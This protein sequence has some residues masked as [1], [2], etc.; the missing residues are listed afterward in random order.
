VSYARSAKAV[1]VCHNSVH[2]GYYVLTPNTPCLKKVPTF[3]LVV[4]LSNLNGFSKFL[5]CGKEYRNLLQNPYDITHFTLGMLLHWLGKLKTQIFCRYSADIEED[6]NKL[7]F[8]KLSTFELRDLGW[9]TCYIMSEFKSFNLYHRCLNMTTTHTHGHSSI[10]CR[11]TIFHNIWRTLKSRRVATGQH[12][13]QN[14]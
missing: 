12:D 11:Y 3:K 13:I 9:S 1:W 2:A 5:H 8:K 6:A 14:Y 7:H 10:I 4:T